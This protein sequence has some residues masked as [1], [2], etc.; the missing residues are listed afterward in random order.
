MQT[1]GVATAQHE[2][3]GEFIH[4]DDLAVFDD[5]V[6]IALHDAVGTKRLIDVVREGGVF[7]V[8]KVLQAEI[9]LRLRDAAGGERGGLGLLIHHVI[10]V[11]ILALFFFFIHRG[12]DHS[13]QAAYEIISLTVKIRALITLTGDD[14]RRPGFIDE[15]G[16]DF[17]HNGEHMA[18]LDH[19]PLVQRHIITQIVEA[20]LVVGTV[21]D[22]AGIRGAAL[23]RGESVNDEANGQ[24]EEAMD[25]SH[26]FAV[27]A[28]QVVVH[29][30]D[31]N[32]LSGESIQIGG[33]HGH[34]GLAF[35][36][37]HLGDTALVE[38]DAADQLHAEGFHSQNTPCRLTGG[39]EGFGKKT[40]QRFSRI[41]TLPKF[42]GLGA[43]LRIGECGILCIQTFD[44]VCDG[45]DL[46]Q[47]AV[48]IA[49]EKFIQKTHISV[50]LF[51]FHRIF[52]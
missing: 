5:V 14:Q 27:A 17:V 16:V 38:H 31:V 35:A 23:L 10:G 12:I 26:P 39:G 4:D 46:F 45:G 42:I 25:F 33:Q 30:N 44:G 41:E 18:A 50:L 19:V 9:A 6:D 20:H 15:D 21:S 49:S 36:G 47:F 8:R 34:E 22:V 32:A 43:Q 48:G 1:F 28:G 52:L 37:L 2:T 3:A 7:D 29:G 13:S 51:S 11:Q 40:V 24:S